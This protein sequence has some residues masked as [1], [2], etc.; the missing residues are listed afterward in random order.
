MMLNH[1]YHG[2]PKASHI[3]VPYHRQDFLGCFLRLIASSLELR[4]RWLLE[5]EF[6]YCKLCQKSNLEK[7]SVAV[8]MYDGYVAGLRTQLQLLRKLVRLT[9]ETLKLLFCSTM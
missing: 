8:R 7:V 9:P 6:I 1:V 3:L 2:F 5:G 4:L